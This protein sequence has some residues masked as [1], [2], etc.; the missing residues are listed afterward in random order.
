M[1]RIL[2]VILVSGVASLAAA[3]AARV[4]SG[5]TWAT[6]S[7][8]LLAVFVAFSWGATILH[9]WVVEWGLSYGDPGALILGTLLGLAAMVI[10]AAAWV[11]V[12]VAGVIAACTS[13]QSAWHRLMLAIAS[14]SSAAAAA[15]S[16]LRLGA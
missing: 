10:G 6:A 3:L 1:D 5:T 11:G 4:G 16:I 14:A 13:K 15:Y 8:V 9:L 12:G 7:R 2:G